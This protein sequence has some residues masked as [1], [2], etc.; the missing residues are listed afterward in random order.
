VLLF[1]FYSTV[2][3]RRYD[4]TSVLNSQQAFTA[5]SQLEMWFLWLPCLPW[6]LGLRERSRA[7]FSLRTFPTL[8][9]CK[10]R[11]TKRLATLRRKRPFNHSNYRN[12][13]HW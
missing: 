10:L 13:K 1:L 8:L 11:I 12:K 9:N 4:D 6:S 5:F 3:S 2:R 7:R